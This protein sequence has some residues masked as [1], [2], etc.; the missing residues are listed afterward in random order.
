MR[1]SCESAFESPPPPHSATFTPFY[2]SS[3]TAAQL[4]T[5]SAPTHLEPLSDGRQGEEAGGAPGEEVGTPPHG[6]LHLGTP[7]RQSQFPGC[8]VGQVRVRSGGCA[9]ECPSLPCPSP[10]L[11]PRQGRSVAGPRKWDNPRARGAPLMASQSGADNGSLKSRRAAPP[12]TP[13]ALDQPLPSVCAPK[14]AP[15]EWDK[16]ATGCISVR[17]TRAHAHHVAKRGGGPQLLLP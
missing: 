3:S 14:M 15:V 17:R 11:S 9:L 13:F 10:P 12:R 2:P 7:F 1:R 6:F 8:C 5:C 4:P 16:R